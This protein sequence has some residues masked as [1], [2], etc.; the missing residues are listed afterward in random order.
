MA[1]TWWNIRQKHSG[2]LMLG[3]SIPT[4]EIAQAYLDQYYNNERTTLLN[5]M[6]M[7]YSDSPPLPLDNYEVIET[8]QKITF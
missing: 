6:R 3:M 4:K 1:Q 2:I 5:K 7:S 8:N